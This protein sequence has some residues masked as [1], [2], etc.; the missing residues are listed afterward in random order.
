MSRPPSPIF[1]ALGQEFFTDDMVQQHAL[2]PRTVASYRDTFVLLLRFTER[3]L[4][5][6][7]SAC[8]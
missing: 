2:S 3:Q 6:T 5:K 7:R 4:G 1:A 8:S